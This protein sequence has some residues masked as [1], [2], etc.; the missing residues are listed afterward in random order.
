MAHDELKK[1]HTA[2]IDARHGY[3]EAAIDAETPQLST[4][5]EEM[6]ALHDAHHDALHK[7]LIN[8]GEDPDE[9]G[10]FM[11]S[12]HA[13]I[14]SL[15]ASITGLKSALPSFAS[16]EERLIGLYDDALKGSPSAAV[17]ALLTRQKAE[18]EAKAQ[19]M[20]VTS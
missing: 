15:R 18:L 3:E 16:G 6:A 2:V 20:K 12:V 9:D 7:V 17:A 19:T 10:S 11:T 8:A 4:L 5:F 14:I 13:G 1:L